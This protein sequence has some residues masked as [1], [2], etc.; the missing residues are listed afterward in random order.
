[1]YEL[2]SFI[3]ARTHTNKYYFWLRSRRSPTEDNIMQLVLEN[4]DKYPF[5]IHKSIRI[6]AYHIHFLLVCL[7][8]T[9][10]CYIVVF[11]FP[12]RTSTF[13]KVFFFSPFLFIIIYFFF[14]VSFFTLARTMICLFIF[15]T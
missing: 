9:F 8:H 1:M 7:F 5:Y 2:F 3:C 14:S 15:M 4:N 10:C 6:Y 13:M 11:A 12:S